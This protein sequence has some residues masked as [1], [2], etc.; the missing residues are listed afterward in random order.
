MHLSAKPCHG[1]VSPGEHELGTASARRA[2]RCRRSAV[3][4]DSGTRLRRALG[5]VVVETSGLDELHRDGRER[6]D[7]LAGD[8]RTGDEQDE[9]EKEEEVEDG[10][11]DHTTLAQLR[12]LERV[13]RGT[14]LTARTC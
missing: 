3:A 13:D 5:V 7:E 14:N 12:L 10:V 11:A 9:D 8:Q 6:L 1:L 4:L 2:A